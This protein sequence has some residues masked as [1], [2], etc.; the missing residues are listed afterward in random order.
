MKSSSQIAPS[1]ASVV[2]F[3]TIDSDQAHQ[4]IDNF[5][6][7]QLKGV[8]KSRIYRMLR[9]GEVRVN[10]GRIAASYK[11]Q[12]ED[13]IRIPPVRIAQPGIP[14]S[15]PGGA[16]LENRILYEDEA[17]VLLNKPASMAVHGGSGIAHGVIEALRHRRPETAFLELAHRLDKGVSGCLLIAKK[18][19]VL[20]HLH[21]SF[22]NDQVDKRYLA[23]VLGNFPKTPQSVAVPLLKFVKQGGER[24]VKVA[25]DG[26][27]ARTEF[28]CLSSNR[29]LSFIE[30]KPLTGRTHQIRVH[31]AYLGH[32]IAGDERYGVAAENAVLRRTGL[33]R[34]FLH[35]VSLSFIHPQSEERLTVE[36]PLDQ[37]LLDTLAYHELAIKQ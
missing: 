7:T 30:A 34:I 23:L 31:A 33:K 17:I 4:R 5:L 2:R 6:F 25:P 29:A 18:R 3:I 36:A 9:K 14:S 16:W 20:R 8:P 1:Q 35:A 11:L 21:S 27:A 28:R 12:A 37:E 26:K 24:M 13:V 32:P 19:S 22:R 10:Q 15:A